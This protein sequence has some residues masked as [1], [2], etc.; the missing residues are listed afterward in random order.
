MD[1]TGL[2]HLFG[3]AATLKCSLHAILRTGAEKKHENFMWRHQRDDATRSSR[4][5]CHLFGC[6]NRL[7]CYR[8]H[9]RRE[10]TPT[11]PPPT[12]TA[13]QQRQQQ[14]Q[15]QLITCR[16]PPPP[17]PPPTPAAASSIAQQPDHLQAL[18]GL[19]LGPESH[20]AEL[21]LR[22]HPHLVSTR[23]RR[24]TARRGRLDKRLVHLFNW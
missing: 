20:K 16:P 19:V 23:S 11:A 3:A 8:A 12:T 6:A 5:A 7:P 22:A 15:Q 2:H 18:D 4:P 21:L 9:R 13:T 10:E 24:E 14:R 17:P 1:W